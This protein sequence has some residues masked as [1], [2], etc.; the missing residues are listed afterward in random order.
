ML[1]TDPGVMMPEVSRKLIHAEGVKLISD[2]I[3]SIK[4]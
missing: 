2:W 3:K 4:P 1:S